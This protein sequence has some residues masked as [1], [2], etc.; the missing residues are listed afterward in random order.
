M[1]HY[2]DQATKEIYAY[3]LDGSHDAFVKDGLMPQLETT[4]AA[5]DASISWEY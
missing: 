1:K 3:E 4:V 5:V 2:I